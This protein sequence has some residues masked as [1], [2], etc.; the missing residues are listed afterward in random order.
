MTGFESPCHPS[1]ARS[2]I[3]ADP[4]EL[5]E[6]VAGPGCPSAGVSVCRGRG[7][8]AREADQSRWDNMTRVGLVAATASLTSTPSIARTSTVLIAMLP[9]SQGPY[10]PA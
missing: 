7:S 5:A 2:N 8:K 4:A 10:K 9:S 6:T 1:L 3:A